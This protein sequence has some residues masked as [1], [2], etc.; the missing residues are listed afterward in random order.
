MRGVSKGESGMRLAEELGVSRS[1]VHELRKELQANAR[2]LQPDAPL[3]DEH[4]ETDEMFQNAGEKGERHPDPEDPPRRRANKRR[5]HCSYDNDRPPIV[6]SVGRRT[7]EVRLRVIKHTDK[8][9][10]VPHV[11]RYTA[12]KATV[13]T[14]EWRA[15]EQVIRKHRTVRHSIKE[16]ARDEDGDGIREVHVNTIEGLWT[17]VRNFLRMFRGVH[18]KYLGGYVAMCE[19]AI[20]LKRV[21]PAF[22]SSLVALHSV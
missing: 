8:E 14:D 7:G 20:N 10:L 12:G 4:V 1:T 11:H 21:T 22:I 17:T 5:G 16:W 6:G 2:R 9:T 18:K 19:F 15:Y 3:V 13:H